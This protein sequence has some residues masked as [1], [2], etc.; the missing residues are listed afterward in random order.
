MV[1]SSTNASG[2]RVKAVLRA[3]LAWYGLYVVLLGVGVLALRVLSLPG[4]TTVRLGALL[5][6]LAA[7]PPALLSLIVAFRIRPRSTRPPSAL[8]GPA[9]WALGAVW[10]S[11]TFAVGAYMATLV[12]F[13]LGRI[14]SAES[15]NQYFYRFLSLV[16]VSV[17]LVALAGL[18]FASAWSC[19]RASEAE[20]SRAAFR[21]L[22]PRRH[23]DRHPLRTRMWLDEVDEHPI[24]VEA[25]TAAPATARTIRDLRLVSTSGGLYLALFVLVL[26]TSVVY[27]VIIG[28]VS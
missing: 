24:P 18:L 6:A 21:T 11:V 16:V 4:E 27:P 1:T 28:W 20:F 19:S 22:V 17:M 9:R 14:E 26:S 12:G 8:E 15:A 13:D 3:P 7:V 2:S 23:L 25:V 10:T 5:T